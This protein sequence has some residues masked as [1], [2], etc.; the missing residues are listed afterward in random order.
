MTDRNGCS[1]IGLDTTK[2]TKLV[3]IWQSYAKNN[4]VFETPCRI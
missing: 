4:S 1:H 3:E 2:T